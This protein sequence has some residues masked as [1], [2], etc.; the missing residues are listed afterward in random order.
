[1]ALSIGRRSLGGMDYDSSGMSEASDSSPVV[2]VRH[3]DDRE[4]P[5]RRSASRKPKTRKARKVARR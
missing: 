4:S 3:P 5:L 2:I 1:M